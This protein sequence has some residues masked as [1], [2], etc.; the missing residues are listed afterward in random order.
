MKKRTGLLVCTVLSF[1]LLCSCGFISSYMP[2]LQPNEP[3]TQ[4][5]AEN[6][7]KGRYYQKLNSVQQK[8]YGIILH[9]AAA[10]EE[11]VFLPELTQEE[12]STVFQS[13]CYDNPQLVCLKN[14]FGWGSIKGGTFIELHYLDS[15]EKCAEKSAEIERIISQAVSALNEGM[16]AFEKELALHDWLASH[17]TYSA[18]S[19]D[20]Y[21]AYGA[22]VE[23]YAA[24]E[25]YAKAMQLLLARAGIESFLIT[26]Q[27]EADGEMTGHMWNI[28]ELDGKN[29]HLDVTWDAPQ[30]SDGLIQHAYF[31]L[32][33]EEISGDHFG[34]DVQESRCNSTEEN[35]F[36]R[37]GAY[38]ES[39]EALLCGLERAIPNAIQNSDGVLE[40]RLA[41]SELYNE[42][43]KKLFYDDGIY[44]IIKSTAE[45][46][47]GSGNCESVACFEAESQQTVLLKLL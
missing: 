25:G 1:C 8:A 19:P 44:D 15:A 27:V 5:A 42:T 38:Y 28:V 16:D 32:S 45:S 12:L 14:K 30:G 17:C 36:R 34:F 39:Y 10:H 6:N 47:D 21:T 13:V 2:A 46:E 26:G 24:C 3:S 9:G 7:I 11:R 37:T 40:F 29:Y 22:L 43:L 33:D 20:A 35:F 18:D 4:G 41:D 23:G 31:N